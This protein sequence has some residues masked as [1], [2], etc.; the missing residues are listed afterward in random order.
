MD[1]HA[2]GILK[3]SARIISR[4]QILSVFFQQE[5]VLKIF[6]RTQV[7]HHLFESDSG[8]SADKLELFHLQFTTSVVE[9]L[10]KIKKSNEKNV[11]LIEEE[12]RLNQQVIDKLNEGLQDEQDFLAGKQR[13]SLKVNNSL[14]NL[15]ELLSGHTT[16]FPFVRNITQFSTRYSRD[17]YYP[18]SPEQF[19]GL[20]ADDQRMVYQTSA[21]T[22]ERK[23]MG[24]LCKCDFKTE[25]F[26]GLKSGTLVIELYK[27]IAL[28]KYFL[29]Y[30]E[31]NLF[32]F[33]QP[34]Q[35][36]AIDFSRTS[37]A[38]SKLIQEMNHQ[39]DKLKSQAAAVK[40]H[41]P[42][43]IV[44]ILEANYAKI[45]DMNFLDNL[46]NFDV[47]ANI[48]RTMLNTDLL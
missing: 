14:R 15:Y 16:D 5:T 27:F 44:S 42:P 13:Q 3:D 34:E 39:N 18:V 37:S 9:L 17:F 40:T 43:E 1:E 32:L 22:I 45:S 47:Q 29:F 4:L 46:S 8:L 30:P 48:L 35:L 10:R 23:L 41:I 7:I 25:F 2:S 6:L 12:I 19:A 31:R 33:Y 36:D 26:C 38:K 24:L 11:L 28:D 21:A 20:V